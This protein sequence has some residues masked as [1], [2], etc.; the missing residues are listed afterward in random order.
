[1]NPR[2]LPIEY[3]V[4]D[5]PAPDGHETGLR[6]RG[7]SSIW[8][9]NIGASSG[10]S[11]EMDEL[12]QQG[13]NGRRAVLAREDGVALPRMSNCISPTRYLPGQSVPFSFVQKVAPALLR[14]HHQSVIVQHASSPPVCSNDP[15]LLSV[16]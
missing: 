13:C 4:P 14:A 5:G 7:A 9:R 15:R 2:A 11:D 8:C 3:A 1:M 16:R 10:H 6:A 12:S